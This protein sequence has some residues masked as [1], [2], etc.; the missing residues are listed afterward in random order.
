LRAIIAVLLRPETLEG[1]A[2]RPIKGLALSSSER[3]R[4]ISRCPLEWAGLARPTPRSGNPRSP[5]HPAICRGTINRA[6]F[7]IVGAALRRLLWPGP[8]FA[9]VALAFMPALLLCFLPASHSPAS[10]WLPYCY[11]TQIYTSCMIIRGNIVAMF[12]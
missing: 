4:Q 10:G 7:T 12:L 5:L 6:L 3:P 8:L 11:L 9:H 2:L 1:L